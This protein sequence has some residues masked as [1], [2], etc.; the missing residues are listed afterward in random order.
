MRSG[1]IRKGGKDRNVSVFQE[2]C[3]HDQDTITI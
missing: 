2:G 3:I 1:L